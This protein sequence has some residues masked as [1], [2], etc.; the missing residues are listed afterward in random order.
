M[1]LRKEDIRRALNRLRGHPLFTAEDLEKAERIMSENFDALA[2]NDESHP[3][4]T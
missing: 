4:R 3:V 2:A 1:Y